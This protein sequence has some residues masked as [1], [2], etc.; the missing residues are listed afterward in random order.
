MLNGWEWW[1]EDMD[2]NNT[3]K[4]VLLLSYTAYTPMAI[5][6]LHK[7]L[8]ECRTLY[9]SIVRLAV[10]HRLGDVP[11]GGESVLIAVSSPHR[12]DALMAVA[13]VIDELKRRVPIWKL[14]TYADGSVW[15]EN[16]ECQ[17]R[18]MVPA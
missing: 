6:I 15:K 8:Q 5:R 16:P 11:V 1:V 3:T 4:D 7:I 17:W 2:V 13:W 14:E 9:P 18:S 10:A 12:R